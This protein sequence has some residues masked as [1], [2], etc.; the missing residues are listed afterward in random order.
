MEKPIQFHID[1][2][3]GSYLFKVQHPVLAQLKSFKRLN[4]LELR[5]KIISLVNDVRESIF[6]Q[7]FQEEQLNKE[8]QSIGSSIQELVGKDC[9]NVLRDLL[10]QH[11]FLLFLTDDPFVP[12]ELITIEDVPVCLVNSVGRIIAGADIKTD[13]K[14]V[15]KDIIDILFIADPLGDLPSARVEIKNILNELKPA[16][17]KGYIDPIVLEGNDATTSKILEIM[18][19]TE[20]EII[21]YAGHAFFNDAVPEE[22][23]LILTDKVLTAQALSKTLN[24]VPEII[25]VKACESAQTSSNY[26]KV[27]GIAQGFIEAGIKIFIG[28]LWPIDDRDASNFSYSFY[29]NLLQEKTVGECILASKQELYNN[30]KSAYG[31]ASFILYGNPNETP[32]LFNQE[33]KHNIENS[34][35]PALSEPIKL[36]IK[37]DASLLKP[38]QI[39]PERKI[40]PIG[41]EDEILKNLHTEEFNI[42]LGPVG[43]GK[44]NCK[45]LLSRNKD[46]ISLVE[47]NRNYLKGIKNSESLSKIRVELE[48][49]AE[50]HKLVVFV[51]DEEQYLSDMVGTNLIEIV[52]L[53]FPSGQPTTLKPNI[54]LL[55]FLRTKSFKNLWKDGKIP[56]HWKIQQIWLQGIKLS[57]ESMEGLLSI[58]NLSKNNFT[59]PAYEL[60]K[61]KI[62]SRNW[63][64]P[65][66]ADKLLLYLEKNHKDEFSTKDIKEIHIADEL[67]E[68]IRNLVYKVR[69][70]E[71]QKVWNCIVNLNKAFKLNPPLWLIKATLKKLNIELSDL[72]EILSELMNEKLLVDDKDEILGDIY[73]F[74]HDIYYEVPQDTFDEDFTLDLIESIE[75]EL[76]KNL[77]KIKAIKTP[78][79]LEMYLNLILQRF[80][81]L[82]VNPMGSPAEYLDDV[83]EYFS[84]LEP[85]VL[86]KI[87]P[88]LELNVLD[89]YARNQIDSIA[90]LYFFIG[91]YYVKIDNILPATDFYNIGC[92]I[93]ESEGEDTT[94]YRIKNGNLYENKIIQDLDMT[95]FDSQTTVELASWQW[96]ASKQYEKGIQTRKL[97]VDTFMKSNKPWAAAELQW[98]GEVAELD[99]KL[100][101]ALNYFNMAI[102]LLET[103]E[104]QIFNVIDYLSRVSG[105]LSRL[106]RS[107]DK[108]E[109]DSKKIELE[110]E[111]KQLIK[112]EGKKIFIL[113]GGGDLFPANQIYYKILQEIP[114][115]VTIKA[116]SPKD[117]YDI[118]ITFGSPLTPEVAPLLFKYLDREIIN[119]M[120]SSSGYWIKKPTHEGDPL[121]ISIAGY[122]MF[123]T[124]LEAERFIQKENFQSLIK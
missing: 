70:V 84:N 100:E 35:I 42:I 118:V 115:E 45:Y 50:K 57:E 88:Y 79:K 81:F 71:Y 22:S 73:L 3:N 77:N 29:H 74:S 113:S 111:I 46:D 106:N 117:K 110:N 41:I 14:K 21:H 76:N 97:L 96:K 51:I 18:K 10:K 48:A 89:F 102:E 15:E 27:S 94:E 62:S 59:T 83:L 67:V 121:I 39:D 2:I 112:P 53:L 49:L 11:E 120:L 95:E 123:H 103:E 55:L 33:F 90:K 66:F 91:D 38:V 4:V 7:D 43:I 65:L 109:F 105:I 12:W 8:L 104:H 30:L 101:D 1:Q 87:I 63:I 116:E 16:I 34:I 107:E 78:R 25:F 40:I 5:K 108:E 69:P 75:E 17:D 56:A 24:Y 114:A 68:S 19:Q 61:R 26:D 93:F 122:T 92:H 99:G 9:T 98:C 47:I 58:H 20:V 52:G 124:R 6:E 31:W 28:S 13:Y 80:Y 23:G 64:Y 36:R 86:G 37:K 44:T 54:R 32:Y 85:K 119:K 60:L 72:K 82:S